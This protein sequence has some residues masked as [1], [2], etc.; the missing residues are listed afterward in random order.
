MAYISPIHKGGSKQDL[1]RYRPVSLT[2]HIAKVFERVIKKK[3]EEFLADSTK[4]N[5][6]LLAHYDDIYEGLW[7]VSYSVT[8]V[9]S[10]CLLPNALIA[11]LFRPPRRIIKSTHLRTRCGSAFPA[12]FRS[13]GRCSVNLD[14]FL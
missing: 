3:I 11:V 12:D 5:K 4:L 8:F 2:S 1:E 13:I 6:G 14:K 9:Q 10:L 7:S